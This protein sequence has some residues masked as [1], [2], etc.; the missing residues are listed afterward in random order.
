MRIVGG[1]RGFT[2]IEIIVASLIMML[3]VAAVI[4]YHASSGASRGQQYYL[5]AV[6]AARAELDKLRAVYELDSGSSE[7]EHTGPPPETIFLF[8]YNTGSSQLELPT[9]TP[10]E[11]FHVYYSDH[12]QGTTLLKPLGING[13]YSPSESSGVSYYGHYYCQT[14]NDFSDDD[15]VDRKTF[16]YFTHDDNPYHPP[17]YDLVERKIDASIA[18]ID[19]M[20]SPDNCENDL[21]GN[22]GWWVEDVAVSGVTHLKKV[23]FA[24]QFWYPGQEWTSVDP[25]VIVLKTTLVKP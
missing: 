14:Y 6:Q 24:F 20:G 18:V 1:E 5:K 8:R 21:L 25:E 7:F 22:M 19:D 2:F 12:G 9:G 15:S 3:I 13:P 16:T 10:E 23:T 4:Q 11:L 17:D